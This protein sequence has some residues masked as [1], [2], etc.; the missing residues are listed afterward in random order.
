MSRLGE[1]RYLDRYSGVPVF[2]VLN[3]RSVERY[4]ITGIAFLKLAFALLI[5]AIG[6]VA[7]DSPALPTEESENAAAVPPG[8]TLQ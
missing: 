4:S 2:V 6:E 8:A 1:Y 7:L 3:S 5:D